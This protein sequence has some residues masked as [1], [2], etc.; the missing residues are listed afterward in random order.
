MQMQACHR[1]SQTLTMSDQTLS[2]NDSHTCK[3]KI[4]D[5]QHFTLVSFPVPLLNPRENADSSSC[6]DREPDVH[7]PVLFPYIDTVSDHEINSC[8]PHFILNQCV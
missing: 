2:E 5:K 7:N 6:T 8:I 4:D 1:R 3:Y